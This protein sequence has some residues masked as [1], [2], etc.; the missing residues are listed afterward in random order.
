[1]S[2]ELAIKV[3][4]LGHSFVNLVL[5]LKVLLL[6]DLNLSVGRVKLDLTIFQGQDL[7]F[8]VTSSLEQARVSRGMVLL[9]V[10]VPLNPKLTRLFLIG[11]NLSQTLDAII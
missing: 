11:D 1:M 4:S 3:L 9:L 2:V 5:E 7:I 8:Q 10:L 6:K